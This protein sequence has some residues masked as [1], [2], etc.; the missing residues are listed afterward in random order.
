MKGLLLKDFYMM[1]KYC[2][3]YLLMVVVFIA[4]SFVNSESL[5]FAFYPCMLCG[6][7]PVTL[8]SYDERSKWLQYSATMPYT[9]AQIVS[10][11]YLIGLCIQAAMLLVTAIVQTLR[12]NLNDVFSLEAYLSFMML[13]AAMSLLTS[14]ITLP[15]MF[16]LGVEKGL[17][18]YYVM[19][20]MVCGGSVIASSVLEESMAQ[21]VGLNAV[22]PVLCL[23]GVG[24]YA[25]SWYLSI[26][27]FRKRE[28]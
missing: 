9:K 22:L 21:E 10:G 3:T 6:M 1:L 12:M 15:F 5:L 19:I 2:R 8:L 4:V 11:K 23:V 16:K 27:F 28:L 14:S 24:V 17:M 25:L 20:G 26:V 18:A 13:L 7:I